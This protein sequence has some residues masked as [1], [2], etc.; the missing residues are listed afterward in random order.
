MRLILET[1]WEARFFWQEFVKKH[2]FTNPSSTDGRAGSH[3]PELII[4][5]KFMILQ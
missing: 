2:Y 4:K 3:T 5:A 1:V